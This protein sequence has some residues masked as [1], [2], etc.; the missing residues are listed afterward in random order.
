MILR[1]EDGHSKGHSEGARVDGDAMRSGRVE[2][3][4]TFT[5]ARL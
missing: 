4:D 3:C 2:D 5:T 1:R